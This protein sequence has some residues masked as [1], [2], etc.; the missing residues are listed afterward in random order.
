MSALQSRWGDSSE[1]EQDLEPQEQPRAPLN[2]ASI[3]SAMISTQ[4]M[5]DPIPQKA[6]PA[7]VLPPSRFALPEDLGTQ[8]DEGDDEDTDSD[9]STA[10]EEVDRE[11]E[12]ERQRRLEIAR[13]EAEEKRKNK[14]KKKGSVEDQLDDLDNILSEMG[15]EAA[16]TEILDTDTNP[17]SK[18]SGTKTEI[19]EG[20]DTRSKRR[21]K[22]KKQ[23]GGSQ[24]NEQKSVDLQQRDEAG[25]S[26]TPVDADPSHIS[27]VLKAKAKKKTS[28]S[29]SLTSSAAAAAAKELSGSTVDK[30]KK[31]KKGQQEF[32]R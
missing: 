12:Q 22:K 30:K 15:I 31:K 14:S 32:G 5:L 7:A 16:P 3:P 4:K 19:Q 24:A 28:R 2:D 27:A 25:T 10:G 23:S 21:K 8:D 18:S 1:E 17:Q 26:I 20:E 29:S 11:A 6:K 9:S 13:Q